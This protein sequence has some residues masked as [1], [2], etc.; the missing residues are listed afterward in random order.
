MVE[1]AQ[2]INAQLVAE[3]IETQA[4]FAAVTGLGMNSGQGYS[5]A[6]PR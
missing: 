1:F 5:W 3:G 6:G 4:E 2:Q